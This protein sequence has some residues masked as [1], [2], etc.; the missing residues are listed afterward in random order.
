MELLGVVLSRN[1]GLRLD[2]LGIVLSRDGGLCLDGPNLRLSLQQSH[3][4][5]QKIKAN[6]EA[7]G[8]NFRCRS[9]KDRRGVRRGRRRRTK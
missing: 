7:F 9:R 1:G 6:S 5:M 3:S 2:R 4:N 8:W